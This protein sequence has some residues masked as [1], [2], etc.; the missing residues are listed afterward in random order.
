MTLEEQEG[1]RGQDFG[2]LGAGTQGHPLK[3]SDV[4]CEMQNC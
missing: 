1:G 2:G 4:L 3:L